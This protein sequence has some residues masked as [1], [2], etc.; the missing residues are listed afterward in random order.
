MAAQFCTKTFDT[1]NRDMLWNILGKFGSP[2]TFVAIFQQSHTGMCAQVL[3]AGSQSSS[4]LVDVGIKQGCVLA[5]I[6]PN[7]YLV[8]MTFVSSC[9][10]QTS[11]SFGVEFRLD[12]D[13]FN[14]R[15]TQYK[16]DT[17]Y[18]LIS[19]IHYANDAAFPSLTSEGLQ[20]S[21]DVISW[22]YLYAGH[23]V[24]ATKTKT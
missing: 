24:N 16:T 17:P 5:P 2:P 8:A 1:V 3:M 22:T 9:D 19:A 11:D 14:L 23:I 6:I 21:L 4:F 15:R 12:G 7:L 13:V 10:I 18:A 20:R